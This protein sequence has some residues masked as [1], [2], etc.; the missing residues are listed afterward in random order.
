[1][2]EAVCLISVDKKKVYKNVTVI[3]E[4]FIMN[5]R[6]DKDLGALISSLMGLYHACQPYSLPGD[7][8][9]CPLQYSGLENSMDCI[10]HAVAKSWTRLSD[11]H[12]TSYSFTVHYW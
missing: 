7:G 11:F 8:K 1:V 9:G 10:V 12:F 6:R 3:D 5:H 4:T 2:V